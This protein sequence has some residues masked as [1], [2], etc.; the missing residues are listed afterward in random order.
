MYINWRIWQTY[1]SMISLKKTDVHLFFARIHGREEQLIPKYTTQCKT[2]VKWIHAKCGL[3]NK[4]HFKFHFISLLRNTHNG[5][6]FSK[7]ITEADNRSLRVSL[8]F[9]NV[10]NTN[11]ACNMVKYETSY[12]SIALYINL[13]TYTC[14]LKATFVPRRFLMY[15]TRITL[16]LE[17]PW[18]I[19]TQMP[20]VYHLVAKWE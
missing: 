10:S 15:F 20:H 1:A 8:F 18:I 7:R 14:L 16:R 12:G 9:F 3:I 6:H 11:E 2:Q 17:F 4:Y 19:N 13:Y 5:T